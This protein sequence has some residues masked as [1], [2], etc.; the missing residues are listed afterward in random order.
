MVIE[1]IKLHYIRPSETIYM[2]RLRSTGPKVK[3]RRN[4]Y[5]LQWSPL[6]QSPHRR[7]PTIYHVDRDTFHVAFRE[8]LQTGLEG[9]I[10][11]SY[12]D[13]RFQI[14]R[15]EFRLLSVHMETYNFSAAAIIVLNAAYNKYRTMF[16]GTNVAAHIDDLIPNGFTLK[17][18]R[19][20]FGPP[21]GTPF[22]V[23]LA[24][25]SLGQHKQ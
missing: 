23:Q 16:V 8:W 6:Q 22:I 15:A 10:W 20:V 17:T 12:N 13:V 14:I 2:S 21:V 1:S 19:V 25:K 7:E 5:K 3:R 9:I 24:I 4:G 11:F 18:R